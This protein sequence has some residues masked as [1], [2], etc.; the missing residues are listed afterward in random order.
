MLSEAPLG[1]R[2]QAWRFPA[3]NRLIVALADLVVVVESR[4]AGGSLLTVEEAVRRGVDVMAV[5]GSLRNGAAMGTNQLIADGCAP[6]LGTDDVLA[7]LGL[8]QSG[9]AERRG[10]DAPCERWGPAAAVFDAVD[11]GPT[12]IDEVIARS[13]VEAAEVYAEL[14]RL[15]LAGVVVRDGARV[16]RA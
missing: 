2:P 3:R 16:R 11:D 14:A 8:D 1:A 15:E 7:A 6:V 12:S 4:A 13:G 9:R 10:S 5:P